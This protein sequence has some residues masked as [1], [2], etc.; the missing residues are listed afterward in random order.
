MTLPWIPL[1]AG[2]IDADTE[3]TI[4]EEF[5]ESMS[6]FQLVFADLVLNAN[7]KLHLLSGEG[8]EKT[9]SGYQYRAVGGSST[10]DGKPYKS[11][12]ATYIDLTGL[13]LSK[14]QSIPCT[15]TL[16]ITWDGDKKFGFEWVTSFMNESDHRCQIA[17]TGG[18]EAADQ[19]SIHIV[20][21]ESECSLSGFYW[22]SGLP[23]PTSLR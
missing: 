4:S 13:P 20:P 14:T 5:Q 23:T 10:G 15:L 16:E 1:R 17:G 19:D 22:F 11:E 7:S 6:K 21:S 3:F 8:G 18:S 2:I 12:N 9:V